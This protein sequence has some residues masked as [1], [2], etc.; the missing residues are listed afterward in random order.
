MEKMVINKLSQVIEQYKKYNFITANK[1]IIYH[2]ITRE[3]R[4]SF[5]KFNPDK[6]FYVIRSIDYKNKFYIGPVNNLLA[7]YFYVLSHLRYTQI[8][9]WIPVVDMLNY[10]VYNSLPYP[11]N[12]TMNAWEYFWQQPSQYTLDEVYRSRN[13]ILSKQNWFS[14]YDMGYELSHYEDKELIKKFFQLAATVPLN[15]KIENIINQKSKEIFKNK[16]D[17]L[18]IA[19]RFGGHSKKHFAK[20]TGHPVQPDIEE[21]I[22]LAKIYLDK[23]D[24]QYIFLTSDTEEA[25]QAFKKIFKDKLIVLKRERFSELLKKGEINNLYSQENLYQTSLNYLT[26]MI[27]LSRCDC[28]IGSINSGL[29]YAVIQNNCKY[30]NVKILDYGYI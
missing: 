13:V 8:N 19:F 9:G 24:M 14:Q 25:V 7:N 26:E 30:K 3:K 5:G 10:P 22:K 2:W 23:W 6:T 27:L 1:N 29:R 21:M 20:A 11:I 4:K 15:S 17:I 18:G 12:G 28:L 16:K